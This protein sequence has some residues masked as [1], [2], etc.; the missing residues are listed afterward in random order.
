MN[1][2]VLLVVAG[3]TT[4]FGVMNKTVTLTVDGKAQTIRTFSGH[5]D[6][7]L[8]SKGITLAGGDKV[9]PAPSHELADGEDITVKY[10]RPLTLSVDGKSESQIVHGATVKDVLSSLGV[11]PATGAYL[12]AKP[13]TKVPREGMDLVVSNP[14]EL[15]VIADGRTKEISTAAPTV[16]GVLAEVGVTLDKDDEVDLGKADVTPDEDTLVKP[17]AKLK[18]VRIKTETKTEKISMKFPVEVSNDSSM[19]KGETKIV[20]AGE[21]GTKSEK[22]TITT[23]DGEV[24]DRVVL[25]STVLSQPVKQVEKRGTREAPSIASGSVWDKI[26]QCESGGNWQT[27]TGNGYYGGL[28]FSAATWQS[29]GGSGVASDHTREEQIKRAVILQQR[30]GWGQ[31]GCADARFN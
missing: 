22:V 27:N 18:V 20:S 3:G 31:W 14:K 4:A 5:V 9:S 10:A 24:R 29:V 17:D 7:V 2:A 11:T 26:A 13:D 8:K 19:A 1:L 15:K 30:A 21:A 16:I 23:A 28:Q 6:D 25:A 12:S